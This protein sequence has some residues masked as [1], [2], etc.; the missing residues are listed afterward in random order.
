MGRRQPWDGATVGQSRPREGA[1]LFAGAAGIVSFWGRKGCPRR[2]V[3]AGMVS[4]R[5]GKAVPWMV[6]AGI[7]PSEG[8]DVGAGI[9][10]FWGRGVIPWMVPAG[11]FRNSF[12]KIF[13]SHF[14]G[15]A[16]KTILVH[17]QLDLVEIEQFGDLVEIDIAIVAF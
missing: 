7:V 14:L 5:G 6:P 10:S 12:L 13:F 11:E 16:G 4:S 3:P 2:V 17:S 8:E 15:Q 9:V 1:T